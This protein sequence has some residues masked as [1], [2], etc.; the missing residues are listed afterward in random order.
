MNAFLQ[1]N[2]EKKIANKFPDQITLPD[3]SKILVTGVTSI[4]GWPVFKKLEELLPAERLFGT[5]PPKAKIP[6]KCNVQPTCMTDRA[7][8]EKIRDKFNPT[9]VAHCAG[10]CDLDVCEERPEWAHSINVQGAKNVA[11]VF[12]DESRII[13]MSSDLV[14]SGADTPPGGYTEEDK[15]CPISVTGKTFALAE[16]EIQRRENHCVIRISLPLGDSIKGDKGAIDWIEGRFRRNLPVTLFYDEYRSCANCDDIGKMAAAA[17]AMEFNGL[18]HFGGAK[19][20]SLF[21]IG[22]FVLKNGGY[23]PNLLKGRLRRHE[24][25][26]PPRVGDVSLNSNKLTYLLTNA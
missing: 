6:G 24:I 26:G 23:D 18:F 3:S 1:N 19:R 12:G 14:F 16:K 22:E 8:L 13:Y 21:D 11:D 2:G 10:V 15:L 7:S 5:C 20:W 17:L 25:D 4:H 9:H